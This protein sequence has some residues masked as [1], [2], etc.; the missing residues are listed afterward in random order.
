M[1]RI[2]PSAKIREEIT[3]LLHD[4]VPEDQDVVGTLLRLGL[5]GWR[6]SC[7]RRKL[8]T[9]LAGTATVTAAPSPI[10]GPQ[11]DRGA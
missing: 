2:A 6:R 11:R 4:G 9:S 3:R 10:A 1:P 7:S 8:R 5:G